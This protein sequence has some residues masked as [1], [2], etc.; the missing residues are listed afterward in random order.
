[1]RVGFEFT[2][3]SG[4]LRAFSDEDA[5]LY[6]YSSNHFTNYMRNSLHT[7]VRTYVTLYIYVYLYAQLSTY[8]CT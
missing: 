7:C 1:M 2:A 6:V 3:I 4:F 5:W 8:M